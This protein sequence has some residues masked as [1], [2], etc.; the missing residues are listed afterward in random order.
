[1][2]KITDRQEKNKD[3]AIQNQNKDKS[4]SYI[5]GVPVG[6]DLCGTCLCQ[7]EYDLKN[8]NIFTGSSILPILNS[9]MD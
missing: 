3:Y 9:D 8:R 2:K 7:R 4:L 1:M 5:W 6:T